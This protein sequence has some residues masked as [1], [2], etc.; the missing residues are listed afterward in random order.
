MANK[1][2]RPWD[3]IGFRQYKEKCLEGGKESRVVTND[4]TIR[5]QKLLESTEIAWTQMDDMNM[6]KYEENE[7]YTRGY[8]VDSR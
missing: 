5:L 1:L 3:E 7:P 4:I 6:K 2:E 8:K